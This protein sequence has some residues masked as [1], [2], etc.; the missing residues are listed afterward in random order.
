MMKRFLAAAAAIALSASLALAATYTQT[1][2]VD[3]TNS[4][5]WVSSNSSAVSQMSLKNGTTAVLTV[6]PANGVMLLSSVAAD[7]DRVAG[8]AGR[9]A[10]A[11]AAVHQQPHR[12]AGDGIARAGSHC[13][14]ERSVIFNELSQ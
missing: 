7:L 2:M 4:W 8:P 12:A 11:L 13:V 5:T 3:G 9:P 1:L 14:N 10:L 6:D